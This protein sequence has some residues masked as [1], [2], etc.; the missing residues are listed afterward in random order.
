[1]FNPFFTVFIL[2]CYLFL[3][4]RP[5]RR[6]PSTINFG[7]CKTLLCL[8]IYYWIITVEV[9]SELMIAICVPNVEPISVGFF[10]FWSMKI[11]PMIF[12]PFLLNMWEI[13][14][15]FDRLCWKKKLTLLQRN[16]CKWSSMI[17]AH[18]FACVT[19]HASP[20]PVSIRARSTFHCTGGHM[21]MLKFTVNA[22]SFI[23]QSR[24]K[25]RRCTIKG[26]RV[27]S[28][29]PQGGGGRKFQGWHKHGPSSVWRIC[30]CI[31]NQNP[32]N[33]VINVAAMFFF[34]FPPSHMG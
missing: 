1:M 13:G 23:R 25:I 32:W 16:S 29:H 19:E 30:R 10:F 8:L 34:F 28:V 17:A 22:E 5:L 2:F 21:R 6:S 18:V 20:P 24:R 9:L 31:C 12:Y 4:K 14:V 3:L 33:P 27:R 7:L 26:C 11:K 15:H